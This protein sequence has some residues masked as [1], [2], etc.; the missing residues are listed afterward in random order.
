LEG[1]Q[2]ELS[3]SHIGNQQLEV[4]NHIV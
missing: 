4:S 1:L 2:K 3:N